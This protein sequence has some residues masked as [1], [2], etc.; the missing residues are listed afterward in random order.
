MSARM[1]VRIASLGSGS[2]GNST[3]VEVHGQTFLVDVGFSYRQ[4]KQRLDRVCVIPT[5][6]DAVFITHEHSDHIKGLKTFSKQHPDTPIYTTAMNREVLAAKWDHQGNWKVFESGNSFKIADTS[7]TGIAIPHDA[8]EPVAYIFEHSDCK[9]SIIT[10][11]GYVPQR[12]GKAVLGSEFVLLEAN[13]DEQLLEQD[14]KRPWSIKQRIASRHGHLS[15]VQALDFIQKLQ[16]HGLKHLALGHLS[17]D[18]N[19]PEVV[20]QAME[21]IQDQIPYHILSQENGCDWIE[22]RSSEPAKPNF[23]CWEEHSESQGALF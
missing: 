20:V 19:S 18:C 13:Y 2:S 3:V 11:L 10:D 15:N 16:P 9:I 6:I 14:E 5:D 12:V 22:L 23:R 1:A 7:V 8:V 17:S 4:L 21:P